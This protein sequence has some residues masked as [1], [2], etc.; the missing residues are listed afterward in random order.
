MA[1]IN[2][3]THPRYDE[4]I[5][6]WRALGY[7]YEGD[8]PY[9]NGEA[10]VPHTRELNYRIL[11]SG[12]VDFDTVVSEKRKFTQRK[13]LARYENFA[14]TIVD[15]LVDHQYAK[16][17]TRHI[18]QPPAI[19]TDP[20]ATEPERHPIH[21]FWEDV[22]GEGTAIDDWLK[23]Y[24][25]LVNVYGHVFV[26]MDRL[27]PTAPT[28]ALRRGNIRTIADQG[29]LVLRVYSPVD[30]PDWLAPRGALSAV[31]LVEPV[32][33][34]TLTQR[35]LS[36]D[37]E[38]VTWDRVRWTRFNAEGKQIGT[39]IHGFDLLPVMIWYAR[40]R[41]RIPVIG[42]SVLR[43]P[44]VFQDH[45][46]LISE[47]RELFRAQTF[48]ILSVGLGDNETIQQAR[49]RLGEHLGTD[50]I[51]Y[52]RGETVFIAPPDG[53]AA[54]YADEIARVERVI[55][56]L[57]GLPWQTDTK[58]AEAEGSLQIKAADLN[59]T[60]AGLADETERLEYQIARRWFRGT[61][62]ADQGERL[63]KTS[64]LRIS[65]PEEFQVEQLAQALEDA[66][67]VITL[68]VGPTATMLIK[69]DVVQLR[70]KDLDAETRAKIDG[71]LK[72]ESA[73]E[74][75]SKDLKIAQE[76]KAAAPEPARGPA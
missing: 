72:A 41:S 60:L 65:H 36:A 27:Q 47:L 57:A 58:E 28:E 42:R 1:V 75:T 20:N 26:L 49:D 52:T 33:R 17:P 68:G 11:S 63:F 53:P 61:Y 6:V 54:R 43:D 56:R 29:R 2:T 46:N 38:Y 3:R 35:V 73:R 71:E 37:V 10:L 67:S 40:R 70:L 16:V 64:G 69:Q 55:Y 4:W 32:E 51:M 31:K 39:G 66:K 18:D 74:E 7:V 44:K 8:G 5:D 24:Q 25:S 19:S 48:S 23:W 76:R 9:L 15:T 34:R 12:G 30:V 45:Y 21:D 13:R 14:S 59:R 22:D 50:S 62:G